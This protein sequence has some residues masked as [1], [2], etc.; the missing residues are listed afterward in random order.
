VIKAGV[1]TVDHPETIFARFD[2]EKWRGLAVDADGVAE[3]FLHP[4]GMGAVLRRRIEQGAI[5][6]EL[7]V[8]DE[9]RDF[10]G[11]AG[12]VEGVFFGVANEV[13]AGQSSV[14]IEAG[15][16]EGMIVIPERGGG[17]VVGMA[18][19]IGGESWSGFAVGS[20]PG[21]GIAV[22]I[23]ENL[24][25]VDVSDGADFGD[26]LFRAVDGVI[27]GKKMFGGQFVR[28]LDGKR[29]TLAGFEGW[30]G[31]H[32]VVAPHRGGGKI[33]MGLVTE[34]NHSDGNDYAGLRADDGWDG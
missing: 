19:G 25:A 13:H 15:D 2:F 5:G 12:K 14:D 7:A 32:T 16:A 30:S 21:V 18:G 22:A 28:P 27:D 17:L 29:L 31:P 3:K 11:A 20:D 23:R 8:L 34:R 26:V 10:V 24:G 1:G 6:A 33:A 9:K 4:H